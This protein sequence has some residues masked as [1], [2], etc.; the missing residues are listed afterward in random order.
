MNETFNK[1]I[2]AGVHKDK[3]TVTKQPSTVIWSLSRKC[4]VGGD[5]NIEAMEVIKDENGICAF[6]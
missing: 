2:C 6:L 4:I 5:T 3:I 1:Y